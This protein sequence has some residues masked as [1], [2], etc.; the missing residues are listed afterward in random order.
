MIFLYPRV[1]SIVWS[2]VLPTSNIII[3]TPEVYY[4]IP[5]REPDNLDPTFRW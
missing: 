1:C 2:K 5:T 4:F 3:Y